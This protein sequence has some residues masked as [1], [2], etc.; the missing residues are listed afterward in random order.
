MIVTKLEIIEESVRKNKSIKEEVVKNFEEKVKK[1][2]L[3]KGRVRPRNE[4][5]EKILNSFERK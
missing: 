3:R 2:N 5:K 1:Q 4:V